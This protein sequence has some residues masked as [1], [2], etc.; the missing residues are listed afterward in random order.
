MKGLPGG[1]IAQ[2]EE[3]ENSPASPDL[4]SEAKLAQR[5]TQPAEKFG[6]RLEMDEVKRTELHAGDSS[7]MAMVR[8][9][10][11]GTRARR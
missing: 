6:A 5:M 4:I 11:H 7:C 9:T 1:Q 10:W 8:P 2:T 3:V